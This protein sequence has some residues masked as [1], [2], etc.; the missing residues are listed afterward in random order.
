MSF[1]K[2]ILFTALFS[3]QPWLAWANADS[4][5]LYLTRHMEK[6]SH[7]KANPSLTD[8]GKQQAANLAQ[9]LKDKDIGAI[10]STNYK[11]TKET[12]APLAALLGIEVVHYDP[13]DLNGF[14]EKVK[15]AKTNALIVGHS[16]TTPALTYLLSGQPQKDI[17]ESDYSNLFEVHIGKEIEVTKRDLSQTKP[18]LTGIHIAPEKLH[19]IDAKYRMLLRGEEVGFATYNIDVRDGNIYFEEKTVIDAFGID[20][21]ISA[22]SDA[23]YL[24][25]IKLA[26]SGSM[27]APSEISLEWQKISKTQT[28]VFGTSLMPRAPYKAQGKLNVDRQLEKNTVERTSALLA[29][30]FFDFTKTHYFQ[31]FNGY[32]DETRGIEII[33]EGMETITVPAGIFHTNKVKLEGG[34][35]SQLFYLSNEP[36]PKVIKIEV[37]GMPWVYELM[38]SE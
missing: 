36:Q 22:V 7:S 30:P 21:T 15:Q 13:N 34:A 1:K 17:D 11:R 18:H 6:Q 23:Q 4:F 20:A 2:L 3:L 8:V 19:N 37:L 12:A 28:R 33:S 16:N 27:G 25:P 14:A 29:I 5:T 31:W 26:M 9:R 32:E 24:S 35:P 38:P 10:Y